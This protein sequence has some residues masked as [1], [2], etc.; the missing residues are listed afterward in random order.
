MPLTMSS[1]MK[2]K[3]DAIR[4]VSDSGDALADKKLFNSLSFKRDL[5]NRLYNGFELLDSHIELMNS[6]GYM[7]STIL[8]SQ[9]CIGSALFKVCA[10]WLIFDDKSKLRDAIESDSF[11]G[12][13]TFMVNYSNDTISFLKPMGLRRDVYTL[14]YIDIDIENN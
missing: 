2:H 8:C 7:K 13:I 11:I 1:R 12:E 9:L 5:Y 10:Q 14:K 4:I 6:R 3:A